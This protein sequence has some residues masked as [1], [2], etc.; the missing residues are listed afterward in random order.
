MM[1]RSACANRSGSD[2]RRLGGLRDLLAQLGR[3]FHIAAIVETIGLEPQRLRD[4]IRVLQFVGQLRAL[5]REA[6]GRRP[7]G[8]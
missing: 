3:A 8:R 4:E 2:P 5:R 1:A 6:P 7:C